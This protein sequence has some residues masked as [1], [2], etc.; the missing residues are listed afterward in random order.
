[1]KTAAQKRGWRIFWLVNGAALFAAAVLY[2]L[3][4]WL[5]S[6]F[7]GRFAS[8][9]LHDLLHIY[10]LTCGATRAT[11][12][13]LHGQILAA[14]QYHAAVVLMYAVLFVIDLRA[15]FILLRG[16]TR[17]FRLHP[18]VWWSL[19]ALFLGYALIRDISLV[20]FR[21]DWIGDFI[22]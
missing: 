7:G 16:G 14:L 6:N 21:W 15:F 4:V 10:C 1:M 8:C 20:A 19:A 17:P 11:G 5:A 3:S 18:A 22:R 9:V 2:P 12:A 13:L